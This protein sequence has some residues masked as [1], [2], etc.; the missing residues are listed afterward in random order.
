MANIT[1][2]GASYTDVPAVDLPATGGGT[3]RFHEVSGSQSITTNGTYD[4]TTKAEVVVNVSGGGG[5][6]TYGL[7][8]TISITEAVSLISISLSSLVQE[9]RR[10][11]LSFDNV[12]FSQQDYM[13]LK[14]GSTT[15]SRG[16]YRGS[17]TKANFDSMILFSPSLTLDGKTFNG[18]IYS[19]SGWNNSSGGATP[20][21]STMPDKLYLMLTN[22]S[23]TF[24]GGT[25][26]VY[27]R[28][29]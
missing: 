7:I 6:P 12:T 10:I 28:T 29:A 26:K 27:G 3:A 9:D 18:F 2:L 13:Y 1:L 25:I 16:I 20:V 23:R 11:C 15:S 8:Q 19:Y 21:V 24:T 4:V 5:T 17:N 22:S 14:I